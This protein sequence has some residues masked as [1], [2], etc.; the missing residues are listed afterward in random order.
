MKKKTG[1]KNLW[2]GT[3][4]YGTKRGRGGSEGFP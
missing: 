3:G 2:G 4:I 1:E